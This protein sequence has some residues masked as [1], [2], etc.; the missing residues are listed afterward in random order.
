MIAIDLH[1]LIELVLQS[2]DATYPIPDGKLLWIQGEHFLILSDRIIGT[3]LLLVNVP[4]AGTG[5]YA[6]GVYLQRLFIPL[7]SF[8][9][10]LLQGQSSGHGHHRLNTLGVQFHC[11]RELLLGLR[12]LLKR[13]IRL[14]RANVGANVLWIQLCHLLIG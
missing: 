14:P 11:F 10:F 6:F 7:F 9:I 3:F 1:S 5:R 13:R 4:E 2:V 12:K 8:R